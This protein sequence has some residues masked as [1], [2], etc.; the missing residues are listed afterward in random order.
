MGYFA[1][2]YYEDHRVFPEF[3]KTVIND[4]ISAFAINKFISVFFAA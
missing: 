2:M 3:K 1:P 4:T